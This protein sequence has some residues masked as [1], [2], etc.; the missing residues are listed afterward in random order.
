MSQETHIDPSTSVNGFVKPMALAKAAN[1]RPQMVYNYINK[2][3]RG[4]DAAQ[5]LDPEKLEAGEVVTDDES[6]K[7]FIPLEVA[8]A[9]VQGYLADKAERASRRETSEQDDS[10]EDA[11]AA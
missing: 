11:A 5:R 9:F 1:V 3:V 4:L 8:E 7:L 2:G 6:G 10:T